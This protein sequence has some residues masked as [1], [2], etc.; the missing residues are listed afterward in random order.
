MSKRKFDMTKLFDPFETPSPKP[1][2]KS[3]AEI[4]QEMIAAATSP[5]LLS[6]RTGDDSCVEKGYMDANGVFHDNT[7]GLLRHKCKHGRLINLEGCKPC[8]KNDKDLNKIHKLQQEVDELTFELKCV[9]DER[10][11]LKDECDALQDEIYTMRGY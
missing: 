4:K 2:P 9:K 7:Q 3:F 10:D 8:A 6:I 11:R 5:K 1:V